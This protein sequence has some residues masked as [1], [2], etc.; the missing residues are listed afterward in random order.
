MNKEILNEFIKTHVLK[1]KFNSNASKPDFW[2]SKQPGLL[3]FLVSISRKSDMKVSHMVYDFLHNV[4]SSPGCVCGSEL[5]FISFNA[6]YQSF[7][8]ISCSCKYGTRNEK[9]KQT[10]LAKYGDPNYNNTEKNKTTCLVKYGDPNYNNTEK[11]KTTCLA[12]YGISSLLANQSLKEQYMMNKYGVINS[13]L[14]Q[15]VQEKKKQNSLSKRGVLFQ[16]SHLT[17]EQVHLFNDIEFLKSHSATD[18]S[19]ITG[20]SQSHV[21]KQLIK[22]GLI[23]G[24]R[25]YGERDIYNFVKSSYTGD[26]VVNCRSAIPPLEIDVFVPDLKFGIEFNGNYYHAGE[27]NKH[28]EKFQRANAV[29]IRLFQIPEYEWLNPVKQKIWKSMILNQLGQSKHRIFARKCDLIKVTPTEANTFLMENHLQGVCRASTHIGLMYNN[30]LVMVMTLGKSRFK[31]LEIELIRMASRLDTNV[32]GGGSKLLAYAKS[33][34]SEIVSFSNN[35]YSAGSFYVNEKFVQEDTTIG[36]CYIKGS[37]VISRIK[38]QKHKLHRLVDKFDSALTE[39]ENM[40][41]NGYLKFY[42]SGQT[43]WKWKQ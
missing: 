8:S 33:L 7:C 39:S 34:F 2:E 23:D 30:E 1:K 10:K 27:K 19:E 41:N 43:K 18:I 13:S 3:A 4:K 6:G 24:F 42:D 21:S 25:S 17:L 12:K 38:A 20:Y 26:I 5:R 16:Q 35:N 22:T 9:S 11:N 31:S 14:L 37:V 15:S 28:F 40:Q 36:Y 32:V 29:G